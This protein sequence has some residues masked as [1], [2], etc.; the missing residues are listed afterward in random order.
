MHWKTNKSPLIK[1]LELHKPPVIIRVNKFNEDSAKD[2]SIQMAQAQNSGQK[3]IPVVIDSY[4]GQVYSLMS[5]VAAIEA[6]EIPVATIIEGKAM[7]CGAVLF[8]CGADGKRFMDKNA[9][10][11]IHE[12]SSAYWGKNEEIQASAEETKRLNEKILVMMARNIGK[13]DKFFLDKIHDRGHSDWF[14]DADEA[15]ELGLADQ[16]RLPKLKVDIEVDIDLV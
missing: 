3:I 1:E 9:T 2:F 6:A 8:S 11:M 10:I 12:V 7:S 16:L 13:P 14:L 5:M 4:G 15:L